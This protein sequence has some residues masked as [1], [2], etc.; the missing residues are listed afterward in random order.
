MTGLL[1]AIREID[2][3]RRSIQPALTSRLAAVVAEIPGGGPEIIAT[4]EEIGALQ[5]RL[6]ALFKRM[7]MAGLS[8]SEF[9]CIPEGLWHGPK[10]LDKEGEFYRQF[11]ERLRSE[12]RRSVLRRLINAFLSRY[13]RGAE[14]FSSA[15][16]LIT[17][18]IVH[19]RSPYLSLANDWNAFDKQD[20]TS[21]LAAEILSRG[22]V[23]LEVAGLSEDRW[24]FHFVEAVF[25]DACLRLDPKDIEKLGHLQSLAVRPTGARSERL[26]YPDSRGVLFEALLGRWRGKP[27]P[28]DSPEKRTLIAFIDAFAGDPR[29][30]PSEWTGVDEQLKKTYLRWLASASL[31]Q[32]FDIVEHSLRNQEDNIRNMWKKRRCFW[33]AWV[34]RG[35]V[36]EAWVAFGPSAFDDARRT[37]KRDPSFGS[38]YAK[39]EQSRS[40]YHSALIMK[41][42]DHKV[43]EWSHNGRCWIWP[44]GKGAPD[45]GKSTYWDDELREAP[46]SVVH[47]E[48][49]QTRVNEQIFELTKKRLRKSDWS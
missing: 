35:H 16:D 32:F 9:R 30:F 38:N 6:L 2:T 26:R 8:V 44:E 39:V 25:R 21:A 29:S 43:V 34:D 13:P 47:R 24:T 45:T 10:P 48:G 5:A 14:T 15:A 1:E 40:P 18:E 19:S 27:P 3:R 17:A 4:P 46:N 49:W 12:R 36:D 22:P 7:G 33:Q 31:K 41:F 42:G 37:S 20:G 23:V 28:P 11:L